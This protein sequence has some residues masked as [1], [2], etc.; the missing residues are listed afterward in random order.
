MTY[1]NYRQLLISVFLLLLATSSAATS[2]TGTWKDSN[3]NQPI[4]KVLIV[5]LAKSESTRRIFENKLSE[6]LIKAGKDA[7][8]SVKYFEDSKKIN[9]ESLAPVIKKGNFDQLIIVSVA[10]VDK[11]KRFV[12]STYSASHNNMYG[13]YG[14][15][16]ARAGFGNDF[17]GGGNYVEN[18]IVTLEINMYDTKNEKLIWA[19]TTETFEPGNI[20]KEVKGLSKKIIKSLKKGKLL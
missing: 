6:D 14:S 12:G 18:T 4:K 16:R 9:K 19:I 10:S 7:V 11:E 20:N 5:A 13:Q 15:A 3:Y 1:I 17:G 8:A 2:V